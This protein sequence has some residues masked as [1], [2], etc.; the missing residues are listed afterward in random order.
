MY[1]Y[2]EI[3][4]TKYVNIKELNEIFEESNSGDIRIGPWFRLIK[5]NFL[6]SIWRNLNSLDK[7]KDLKVHD[8]GEVK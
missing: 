8:M 4:N 2:N 1:R 7:I 6:K 5:E 3:Q